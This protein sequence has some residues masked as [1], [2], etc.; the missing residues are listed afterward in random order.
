MKGRPQTVRKI[1][2]VPVI[3]GFKPYGGKVNEENLE[4]VFLLYEEYEALRLSDYEKYSQCESASIMGVSRPTFTRIYMKSREKIAQAFI[5]GRRIIV[6][7]GKVELDGGWYIC[8][9]CKAI[10]SMKEEEQTCAL[11]GSD[12]LNRYELPE[13]SS[14]VQRT[15]KEN[16]NFVQG[17]HHLRKRKGRSCGRRNTPS[18]KDR[19]K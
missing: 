6:E 3:S 16:D 14:V 12:E 5:E 1:S 4:S 18:N 2:F 8:N 19:E 10:F 15:N 13:Q 17:K 7:G 9:H 11:C